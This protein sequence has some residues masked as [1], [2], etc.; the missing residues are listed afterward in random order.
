MI[1]ADIAPD[2]GKD[3]ESSSGRIGVVR[4]SISDL[5]EH[6]VGRRD[7]AAGAR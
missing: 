6:P 1:E 5:L 4:F 2:F 3:F 7:S